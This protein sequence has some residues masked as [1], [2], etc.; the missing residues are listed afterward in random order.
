MAGM[1]FI[2]CRRPQERDQPLHEGPAWDGGARRT[3][4]RW[5]SGIV[6][7]DDVELRR[8]CFCNAERTRQ[9]D[10]HVAISPFALQKSDCRYHRRNNKDAGYS[11]R[12]HVSYDCF[13][14]FGESVILN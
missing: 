6:S 12:Q 11:M 1:H 8:T 13:R 14:V 2:G 7:G 10:L 3:S 4:T 9:L 5:Q